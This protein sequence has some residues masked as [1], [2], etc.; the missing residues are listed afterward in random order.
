MTRIKNLSRLE[1]YP[2]EGTINFSMRNLVY[3]TGTYSNHYNL[4]EGKIAKIPKEWREDKSGYYVLVN[5]HL[6]FKDISCETSICR[7]LYHSGI[8]V[9]KP[10]G[11]FNMKEINS[12]IIYPGFVMKNLHW[13]TP[14]LNLTGK[15]LDLALKLRDKELI[16]ARRIGY[17]PKDE[18][19]LGNSLFDRKINKTYL[20]D[21][22]LWEYH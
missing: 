1:R 17:I 20:L 22:E 5:Y 8:H 9:P 7:G 10:Y 13:C 6:S 15:E 11:F 2:V 18:G 19:E 12:G 4:G 3:D 21:F 14:L 16:K